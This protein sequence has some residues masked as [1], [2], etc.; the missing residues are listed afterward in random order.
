MLTSRQRPAPTAQLTKPS[1]GQPVRVA[2][3]PHQGTDSGSTSIAQAQPESDAAD[4]TAA[5]A[6]A[7]APSPPTIP[8]PVAPAPDASMPMQQ[9]SANEGPLE[10]AT[11]VASV[12]APAPSLPTSTTPSPGILGGTFEEEAGA[13]ALVSVNLD[14]ANTM[15][16]NASDLSAG[17][18]CMPSPTGHNAAHDKLLSA[19][20]NLHYPTSLAP[21]QLKKA[22]S[23][24]VGI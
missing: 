5:A 20:K 24:Q 18:S 19:E 12:A 7:A 13:S 11:I 4:C 6:A 17:S 9:H 21:A 23:V 8:P 2:V 16:R 1:R 22:T 10:P 15:F 3:K 14:I